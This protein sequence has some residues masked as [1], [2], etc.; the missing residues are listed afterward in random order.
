MMV[1]YIQDPSDTGEVKITASDTA[2]TVS[3]LSFFNTGD[4][5]QATKYLHPGI[6]ILKIEPNVKY[7][8]IFADSN[9]KSTIVFGTLDLVKGINP[10]LDYRTP[11]KNGTEAE[12][13]TQLLTD[14]RDSKIAADFYYN[15]PVARTT[16]IDLNP[17]MSDD[18]LSNPL[19]W[20]DT[21]NLNKKFVISEIDADYLTTG[22]TLTKTSRA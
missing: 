22:I 11:G 16:E 6:N 8:E 20:Y 14:I 19:T 13:L 4:T 9:K 5:V 7:L 15:L 1:Y 10:K 21:N 18:L 3:G 17:A 12:K 2:T